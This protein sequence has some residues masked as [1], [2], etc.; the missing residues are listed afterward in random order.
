MVAA[1]FSE[2]LS[3]QI[4]NMGTRIAGVFPF[5]LSFWDMQVI[6]LIKHT[7]DPR[8]VPCLLSS[9]WDVLG[10]ASLALAMLVETIMPCRVYLTLGETKRRTV[11][12]NWITEAGHWWVKKHHRQRAPF[13]VKSS[14]DT[15]V[16]NQRQQQWLLS[17]ATIFLVAAWP[18]ESSTHPPLLLFHLVPPPPNSIMLSDEVNFRTAHNIA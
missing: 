17:S 8:D 1:L 15:T 4:L 3:N 16:S 7:E 18:V 14:P 11:G 9:Y 5:H 13:R 2:G 10:L 12:A 6:P